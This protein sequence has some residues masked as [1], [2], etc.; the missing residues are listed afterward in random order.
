MHPPVISP[1]YLQAIRYPDRKGPRYTRPAFYE[2]EGGGVFRER[3]IVRMPVAGLGRAPQPRTT[4]MRNGIFGG[5]SGVSRGGVFQGGRSVPVAGLG[6]TAVPWQCW[7]VPGFKQCHD[8]AFRALQAMGLE[9]GTP[10]GDAQ[11][12]ALMNGCKAICASQHPELFGA[13]TQG[14]K[15]TRNGGGGSGDSVDPGKTGPVT[16]TTP[17]T[18]PDEKDAGVSEAGAGLMQTVKMYASNPYVQAAGGALA[19]VTVV[20]VVLLLGGD[21]R[22]LVQPMEY[23]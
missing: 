20:T 3:P 19:V 9:T 21:D 6:S 23:L 22:K 18:T 13:S 2:N 12:A 15:E 10:Q 17:T 1:F 5:L 11:F 4:T 7:D 16:T 8:D 14:K